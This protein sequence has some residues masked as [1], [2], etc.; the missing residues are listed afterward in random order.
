MAT[1]FLPFI[2][3]EEFLDF[4]D[5]RRVADFLY[6]G[7]YDSLGTKPTRNEMLSYG[8]IAN[9][10]IRQAIAIATDRIVAAA[11]VGK[12]YTRQ[13]LESIVTTPGGGVFEQSRGPDFWLLA[14]ITADLTFGEIVRR[15][16]LPASQYQELS[17]TFQQAEQYLEMLRQGVRIFSSVKNLPEAGL[18]DTAT[19][20]PLP[21][22]DKPLMSQESRLFGCQSF[23]WY[24]SRWRFK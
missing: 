6:D 7:S 21:N 22:Q 10:R 8:S 11:S 23:D 20:A 17:S 1:S 19:M 12:R 14:R 9:T 13:E 24:N 3:P 16:A 2:S 15:R 18:P 5:S 4:Y